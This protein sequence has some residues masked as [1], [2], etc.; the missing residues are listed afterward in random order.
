[1]L[2]HMRFKSENNSGSIAA[3]YFMLTTAIVGL[4]I[5]SSL[6]FHGTP[7]IGLY[8]LAI[9]GGL[10][11]LSILLRLKP[12]LPSQCLWL[13]S[14]GRGSFSDEYEPRLIKSVPTTFGTNQPPTVEEIRELKDT[15]RNWVPSRTR[16]RHSRRR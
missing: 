7:E 2:E 10:V 9:G 12:D 14:R 15:P 6:A 16:K 1:M 5:A 13:F 8:V 3:A 4:T 11:V